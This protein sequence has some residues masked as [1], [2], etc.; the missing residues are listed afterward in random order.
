[1]LQKVFRYK[2]IAW[3][4]YIVALEFEGLRMEKSLRRL[5]DFERALKPQSERLVGCG[6]ADRAENLT[7]AD[8]KDLYKQNDHFKTHTT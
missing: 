1:M 5:L 3:K 6:G 2:E 4:L 7:D 8:G